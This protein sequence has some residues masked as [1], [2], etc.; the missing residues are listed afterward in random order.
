[1]GMTVDINRPLLL[2]HHFQNQR[3]GRTLQEMS[4]NQEEEKKS[5]FEISLTL[6]HIPCVYLLIYEIITLNIY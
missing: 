6:K 1:M 2:Y 5:G 4:R 3:N